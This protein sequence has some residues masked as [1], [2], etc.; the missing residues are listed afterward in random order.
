LRREFK[1][2]WQIRSPACR[3]AA[4]ML[5]SPALA[6]PT[7]KLLAQNKALGGLA[8]RLMGKPNH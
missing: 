7:V 6:G 1:Q 8:L 3:L 5:S 4:K 2:L